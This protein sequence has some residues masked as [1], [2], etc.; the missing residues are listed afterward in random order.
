[1]FQ[2]MLGLVDTKTRHTISAI[3][4][5]PIVVDKQIN[6]YDT[7]SHR[8]LKIQRK[9]KTQTVGKHSWRGKECQGSST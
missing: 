1:M 7:D 5:Q 4:E 3:K 8:K 9:L 2:G 6:C